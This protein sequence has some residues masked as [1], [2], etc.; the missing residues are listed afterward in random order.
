MNG[1]HGAIGVPGGNRTVSYWDVQGGRPFEVR[2]ESWADE[3]PDGS[4]VVNG[5]K[6]WIGNGNKDVLVTFARSARW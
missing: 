2:V 3:K 5:E 4:W 6:R 1:C